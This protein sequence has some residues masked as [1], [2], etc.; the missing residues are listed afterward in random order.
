MNTNNNSIGASALWF[1]F[2]NEAL[3]AI[4]DCRWQI[5]LCV[6]AI[7]L[8]LWWAWSEHK[9]HVAH[10]KTDEE[11]EKEKKKW[12]KSRAVR[13]SGI[14]LVDYFS[15]L[16]IGMVLGLAFFEPYGFLSHELCAALGVL[17][18][19]ACDLASSWGHFCVVKEIS[20]TKDNALK[21]IKRFFIA[22]V[23]KKSEDI[24]E[25]LEESIKDEE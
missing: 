2:G 19:A 25:A 20:C 1:T 23:K 12:R 24:G 22:L 4:R 7:L 9:Y 14:K 3:S 17:I 5:A 10:C 18:G 8:D 13:R 11:R 21:F 15:F 6:I 16:I